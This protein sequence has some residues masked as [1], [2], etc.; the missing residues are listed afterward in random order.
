MTPAAPVSFHMMR[1]Y[2]FRDRQ[3]RFVVQGCARV[4]PGLRFETREASGDQ[5]AAVQGIGTDKSNSGLHAPV[6]DTQYWKNGLGTTV[7]IALSSRSN[8]WWFGGRFGFSQ[9]EEMKFKRGV[10]RP[11]NG[12][13]CSDG[14][15]SLEGCPINATMLHRRRWRRRSLG[16]G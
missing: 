5:A 15:A 8:A 12:C 4:L 11:V 13:G 1:A 6:R 7:T 3:H 2:F 9:A 16:Q 10:P 14:N